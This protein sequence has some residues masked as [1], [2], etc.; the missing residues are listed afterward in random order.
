MKGMVPYGSAVIPNFV[1]SLFS[2]IIP[3][4]RTPRTMAY[5]YT[6]TAKVA[7]FPY[8][9]YFM[10]NWMY[11]YVL[12]SAIITYPLFYKIR[13]MSYSPANVEKWE[14]IRASYY[15]AGHH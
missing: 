3:Q 14:K 5:P 12:Y 6:I 1:G 9:H 10:K 15:V 11:R 4:T 13:V 7:H 8:K 2:K